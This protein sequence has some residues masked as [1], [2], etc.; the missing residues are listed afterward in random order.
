MQTITTTLLNGNKVGQLFKVICPRL[1]KR[2]LVSNVR[3]S[4]TLTGIDN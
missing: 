1:L 3:T 4:L 2:Y